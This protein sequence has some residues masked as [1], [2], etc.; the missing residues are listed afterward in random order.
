MFF[1]SLLLP[2]LSIAQ[3]EGQLCAKHCLNA[4]LQGPYFTEFDLASIAESID[5]EE[6]ITMAEGGENR[7]EYRQFIAVITF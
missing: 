1:P 7:E 5:E 3:Q 2:S 4:I 6:K